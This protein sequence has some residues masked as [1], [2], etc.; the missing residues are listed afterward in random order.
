MNIEMFKKEGARLLVLE[1][2]DET[3]IYCDLMRNGTYY[4]KGDRSV[5]IIR[6]N[7]LRKRVT[8]CLRIMSDG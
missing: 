3:P 6:T 4:S 2:M 5:P 7:G 8:V 1:N